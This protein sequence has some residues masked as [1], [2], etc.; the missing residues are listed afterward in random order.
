LLK[1]KGGDILLRKRYIIAMFLV[2]LSL[3]TVI[4]TT[5][6]PSLM[7]TGGHKKSKIPFVGMTLSYQVYY[8]GA[9]LP[10][11]LSRMV[12]FYGDPSEPDYIWVRDSDNLPDDLSDDRVYEIDIDTRKIVEQD[13]YSE[14]LFPT[15]LHLGDEVITYWGGPAT[16]IGSQKMSAMGKHM[17]AWVVSALDGTYIMYYEKKTG[18]WLGGSVVWFDGDTLNSFA[19]HLVSTNA[20]LFGED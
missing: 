3:T 17:N 1:E 7:A 19:M 10:R 11:L 12:T 2:A 8:P 15:D 14:A 9:T 16:V 18:I 5:I 4:S 13:G 6:V 20:P